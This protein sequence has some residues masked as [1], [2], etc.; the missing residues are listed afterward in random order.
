MLR[1]ALVCTLLFPLARP[2]VAAPAGG[3]AELGPMLQQ[4]YLKASNTDPN[5]RFGISVAVSGDT[6]VVGAYLES[7]SA[8][9]V[10]GNGANNGS[11]A[12]GAAYVFVR[13]G[14]TWQPRAY[15]KASNTG[16]N[17][18]F[19][20]S[21]DIDGDTIVVGA[22][23]EAS[24][25]TGVDGNQSSNFYPNAGAA[26]VFVRGGSGWTQQAYLKASN[27]YAGNAFGSA[28]AIS[29]DTIIVGAREESSD[30][31]G[32]NGD[33]TNNGALDSGAAYVFVREGATWSQQAY[34]KASNTEPSDLFGV[35][36]AVDGDLAV[37]GATQEDSAATGIDGD[38]SNNGAGASGAGYVYGRQGT[39]WSLLAYL[40]ASNTETGDRYGVS[41]AVSGNTVVV[42]ASQED[43]GPSAGQ[44]DNSEEAAGAA[45][46][47]V[48]DGS[49]WSQQAILK[50]ENADAGDLFANALAIEGE[51]VLVGAFGENSS[52]VGVAGDPDDE[53]ANNS[54]AAYV[55]QRSGTRWSQAA[56]LKASNTGALD[57]FGFDVDL[58]GDTVLV[59]AYAEDGDGIGVGGDQSSDDANSAGAAYAFDLEA[60]GWFDEG[61]ALAGVSGDPALVG[62]GDL[63]P[64][65]SNTVSLSNAAPA[66]SS[67]LIT[68]LSSSPTPFK[69]G[70]LKPFPFL[71]DPILLTT[72]GAGALDLA[73]SMPAGVPAGTELW[74]QWAVQD[75]AAVHGVALSNALLGV[76]P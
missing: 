38:G 11:S 9:G 53:G 6:A 58:N 23:G 26:Y 64:G 16:A 61:C 35:S 8:S 14:S 2:A 49:S 36:V 42:G 30:S 69:G 20:W 37:V 5:D 60:S 71:L 51:R 73:F 44:H 57:E 4:A 54:G 65:S 7:S 24:L 43:S 27:T 45:F 18:L 32:V 50:A 13:T 47:Y 76:T 19:G 39:S 21:V 59:G 72:D 55:F 74:V 48:T 33:Q 28:V 62:M 31:T 67:G 34:L 10:N 17:D 40:K 25:A 1:L 66:A 46:V 52:S 29:G 56:Y 41:V 75:A 12:S 15:L 63:G 68:A 22:T 3:T 70:T